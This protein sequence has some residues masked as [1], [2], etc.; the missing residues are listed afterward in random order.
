MILRTPPALRGTN[1]FAL[2]DFC[3]K[4]SA[5]CALLEL[6]LF[7]QPSKTAA[8]PAGGML[9]LTVVVGV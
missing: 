6:Y 4:L 5:L 8:N 2:V 7:V 3:I 9:Y 1:G